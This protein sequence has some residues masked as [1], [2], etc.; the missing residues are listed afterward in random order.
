MKDKFYN[1]FKFINEYALYG[2]L[3]FLSISNAL[4]EIFVVS[5]FFGFVGRKIIKPDFKFLKFWPN[6]FL[7]FFLLF[8]ALP[9]FNSGAYLKISY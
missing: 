6:I 5:A 7:L 9:L 1:Y 2:L 4:V 3:F 8:S